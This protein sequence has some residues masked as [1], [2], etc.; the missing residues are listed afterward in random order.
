MKIGDLVR[1]IYDGEIYIVTSKEFL[2]YHDVADAHGRQY[3]MPKEH[4][5]QIDEQR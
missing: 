1:H 2:G 4:L 5:E 3:L